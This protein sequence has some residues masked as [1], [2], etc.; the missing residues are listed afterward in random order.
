[1]Q[2]SHKRVQTNVDTLLHEINANII[3]TRRKLTRSVLQVEEDDDD[4]EEP[5][6]NFD[7]DD[8]VEMFVS[9]QLIFKI[10]LRK[11]LLAIIYYRLFFMHQYSKKN[12][13]II[14]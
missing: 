1:M 12:H 9:L 13:K 7:D 11:W 3:L 14:K 4:K 2:T 10:M 6:E 8:D 5:E